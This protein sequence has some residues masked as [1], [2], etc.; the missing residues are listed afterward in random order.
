MNNSHL[1]FIEVFFAMLAKAIVLVQ[2]M[3]ADVN[4]FA[5]AI[6]DFPSF[7][8][9]I[10]A[11]LTE[12]GFVLIAVVA[13]KPFGKFA[14]T[15]NA[16]PIGADLE[17]L[18]IIG[19]VLADRNLSVEVRVN[20]ITIAAKTVAASDTNVM[21][22]AAIFF[23][24]P[25]IGDAFKLGKFALNKVAIKLGFGLSSTSAAVSIVETA[26]KQESVLWLVHEKLARSFA[27]IDS[28]GLVRVGGSEDD[29]GHVVARV[30]GTATVVVA[31]D[32][33]ERVARSHGGAA[34]VSFRI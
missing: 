12:L 3:F 17:D 28:F 20:P 30:S 4:A 15:G 5:V 9:K 16:K 32:D 19:M 6:D 23:G 27:V 1:P 21:F 13:E 18:E 25:E 14:G 22:V 8:A 2:A 26:L 10:L 31:I 7:G 34:L 33:V 29:E 24:F 11:L